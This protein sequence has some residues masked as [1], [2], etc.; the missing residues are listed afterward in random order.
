MDAASAIS[1]ASNSEFSLRQSYEHAV[2]CLVSCESIIGDLQEDLAAKE[3]QLISKDEVIHNLEEK[4]V[5]MS[6][7][8][9]LT[10]GREGELQNQLRKSCTTEAVGAAP[11][12]NTLITINEGSH[13]PTKS[14]CSADNWFALKRGGSSDPLRVSI[15]T[16]A[17]LTT[18]TTATAASTTLDSSSKQSLVVGPRRMSGIGKML[19]G[20][21][22]ARKCGCEGEVEVQFPTLDDKRPSKEDCIPSNNNIDSCRPQRLQPRTPTPLKSSL[23]KSSRSFLEAKGV[24]FPVSSFE[25]LKGCGS[26]SSLDLVSKAHLTNR[27]NDNRRRKQSGGANEEWPEF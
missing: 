14:A 20:N 24:V 23:R 16:K 27:R 11:S 2:Q 7:E 26:I 13:Q 21:R 4:L 5:Q 18:L 19:I 9:A 15:K 17:S 22:N 3:R 6:L 10:K 8:L 12:S 25:V 1:G